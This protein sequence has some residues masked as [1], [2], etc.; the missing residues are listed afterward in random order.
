MTVVVL[1]AVVRVALKHLAKVVVQVLNILLATG[2]ELR[3]DINNGYL[4]RVPDEV[5]QRPIRMQHNERPNQATQ[6]HVEA[7]TID[8]V[9]DS[10]GS[11][12]HPLVRAAARSTAV[13]VAAAAAE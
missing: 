12:L 11:A 5:V 7:V 2:L 8:V 13:T 3:C 9:E 10:L 6:E 1:L 4:F